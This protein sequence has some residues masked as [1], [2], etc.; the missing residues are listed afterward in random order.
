MDVD[1]VTEKDLVR[2][3]MNDPVADTSNPCLGSY[4]STGSSCWWRRNV[5]RGSDQALQAQESRGVSGRCAGLGGLAAAPCHLSYADADADATPSQWRTDVIPEIIDG[6]NI[7]DFV[8]PDIEARLD[9]LEAEEALRESELAALLAGAT[10]RVV[11]TTHRTTFAYARTHHWD[12]AALKAMV[13]D[14]LS[15]LDDEE[16]ALLAE[17]RE[18]KATA[19][20]QSRMTKVPH[21]GAGE[22]HVTRTVRRFSA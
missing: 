17:L 7:A 4:L 13:P 14:E 9:A 18:R 15:E 3:R 22:H 6:K 11:S 1:R 16:K 5:S 8:D 19:T 12:Q 10:R 2:R 20:M 21:G